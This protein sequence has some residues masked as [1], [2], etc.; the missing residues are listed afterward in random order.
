[1]VQPSSCSSS[2]ARPRSL[3]PPGP[4]RRSV[5]PLRIFLYK[6]GLAR[7]CTE[8]YQAPKESNLDQAFMHLTNYAV[9]KKNERFKFAAGGEAAGEEG[10][11]WSLDSLRQWFHCHGFSFDRLWASIADIVVR[12][13]AAIQPQ[14]AQSYRAIMPADNDGFS[15]FEA[16]PALA[17]QPPCRAASCALQNK[18]CFKCSPLSWFD[19]GCPSCPPRC[20]GLTSCWTTSSAPGSLRHL[21]RH[22]CAAVAAVSSQPG[23]RAET[24]LVC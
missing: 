19:P 18:P 24:Q 23:F 8:E 11:K 9:N 17:A 15:C 13:V 7:F 5:D 14:L 4:R 1:M 10:S 22:P 16:P 3:S 21:S 2:T 12:T 20:S 6:E